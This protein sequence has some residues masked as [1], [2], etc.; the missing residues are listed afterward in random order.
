MKRVI[1]FLI[2]LLIAAVSA[3]FFITGRDGRPLARLDR[4]GLPDLK[5]PQVSLPGWL[6][7]TGASSDKVTFYRW[8]DAAGG[9]QVSNHPPPAASCQR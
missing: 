7:G 5:L 1:T 6:G 8:H 4:I 9:V 3:P 2:L